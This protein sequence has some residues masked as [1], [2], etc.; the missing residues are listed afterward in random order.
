MPDEWRV[1][2]ESGGAPGGSAE[3]ANMG[4]IFGDEE[5]ERVFESIDG[6]EDRFPVESAKR[7]ALDVVQLAKRRLT[8]R[9]KP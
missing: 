5:L 1:S 9:S 3:D 8:G 4:G 7:E 6:G 2:A